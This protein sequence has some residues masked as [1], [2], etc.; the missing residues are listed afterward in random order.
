MVKRTEETIENKVM[1]LKEEF[2]DEPIVVSFSCGDDD[3]IKLELVMPRRNWN[4]EES[5]DLEGD[6]DGPSEIPKREFNT[7]SNEINYFG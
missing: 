1:R 7:L 4:N 6:S 5:E 2:D 3:K